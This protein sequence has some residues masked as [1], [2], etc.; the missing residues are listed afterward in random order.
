MIINKEKSVSRVH[1]EII[2]NSM[3]TLSTQAVMTS[4]SSTNV[5]IRDCS[6][7]GTFIN[8]NLESQGKV[9]ELPNKETE[10]RDG[11]IVSFGTGSA[12]YR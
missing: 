6:K 3:T 5:V 12:T 11:D 2:V 1:A 9:H 7:Y 4:S 10:L 8:R